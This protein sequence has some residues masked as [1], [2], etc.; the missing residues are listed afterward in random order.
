MLSEFIF[1][2]IGVAT[3]S[4]TST[5]MIYVNAGFCHSDIIEDNIQGVKVSFLSKNEMPRIELVEPL[6][7][8]SPV[9]LI[10]KKNGTTAYHFC[11]E[12]EDIFLAIEKLKENKFV[13]LSKPVPAKAFDNRKICF[14][15]NKDIGL[16][17]LLEKR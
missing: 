6:K 14:L 2:H 5:S 10:L 13:A 9:N 4:I 1:H 16:I 15:Y 11:Y 3:K 12:V 17:E 8:D 7:P